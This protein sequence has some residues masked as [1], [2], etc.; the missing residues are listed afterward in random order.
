MLK[1]VNMA[2]TVGEVKSDVRELDKLD[3]RSN[4]DVKV[5]VGR[6]GEMH[7]GMKTG[8]HIFLCPPYL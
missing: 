3:K 5:K 2:K 1:G 6:R 4:R 8:R 7:A